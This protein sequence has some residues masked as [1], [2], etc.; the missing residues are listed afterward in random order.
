MTAS[1]N[2]IYKTTM[3]KLLLKAVYKKNL[4]YCILEYVPV[5][6]NI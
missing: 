4:L 5:C 2:I 1:E 6:E 3:E